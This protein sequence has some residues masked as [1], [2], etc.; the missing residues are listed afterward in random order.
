MKVLITGAG[1]QLAWELKRSAGASTTLLYASADDL[2]ITDA[3]AVENYLGTHK[4]DVIINAAAYTAVDKAEEEQELAYAV[5]ETGVANLAKYAGSNCY[6]LQISTDFVFDGTH[7]TP[8]DENAT[9][10]PLSVYGASKLAGEKALERYAT[11]PWAIIR[12][13]WVYSA[14]GN[15]FVKSMLRFMNERDELNIVVDQVGTP[16]WAKGLAELCWHAIDEKIEG[17]YNWSDAGVASWYDFAEAIQSEGLNLGLLQKKAKLNAIPSSGYPTPAERPA[18]SVL[19]KDKVLKAIS[20]IENTHWNEQLK[21]MLQELKALQQ[22]QN[23]EKNL[24]HA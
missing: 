19:S 11:G 10:R 24:D 4:P 21:A 12:T 7:T 22:N 9:P 14:H 13:A 5:N 17:L 18:F 6:L 3:G 1:G 16:T 2:D 8:L 23:E 20:Q 15:N